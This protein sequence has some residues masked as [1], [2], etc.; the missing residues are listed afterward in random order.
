MEQINFDIRVDTHYGTI[1]ILRLLDKQFAVRLE[2]ELSNE[3]KKLLNRFFIELGFMIEQK[4]MLDFKLR[5]EG[6]IL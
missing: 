6:K 3:S 1:L 5:T 4:S 2:E